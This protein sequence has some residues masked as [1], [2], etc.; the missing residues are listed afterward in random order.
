MPRN[1]CTFLSLPYPG[2]LLNWRRSWASGP[3]NAKASRVT[4]TEEGRLLRRRAQ[5]MLDLAEKTSPGFRQEPHQLTGEIAIGSGE[6]MGFSN[7]PSCRS[8]F[9]GEHSS[10]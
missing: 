6:L 9:A 8:A 10:V 2:R 3:L 1:S 4:L 5:E 7:L